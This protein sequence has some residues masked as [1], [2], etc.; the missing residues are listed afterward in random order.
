MCTAGLLFGST[1]SFIL[2]IEFLIIRKHFFPF[3]SHRHSSCLFTS[4]FYV[5]AS[6]FHKFSTFPIID[7]LFLKSNLTFICF[8]RA[9]FFEVRKIVLNMLLNTTL[10][11]MKNP[12][13]LTFIQSFHDEVACYIKQLPLGTQFEQIK[14][15][16]IEHKNNNIP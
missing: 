6:V 10:K 16:T 5:R 12:F 4:H 14:S 3:M 15:Q 2:G 7:A 11:R 13:K 8:S 9:F 1:V